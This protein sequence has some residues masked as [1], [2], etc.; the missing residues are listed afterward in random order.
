L[1]FLISIE[2]DCIECHE[3]TYVCTTMHSF[4]FLPES[5]VIPSGNTHMHFILFHDDL[6]QADNSYTGSF[7][8]ATITKG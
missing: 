4:T 5:D 2:F 1:K 6:H 3:N 7:Q 8:D